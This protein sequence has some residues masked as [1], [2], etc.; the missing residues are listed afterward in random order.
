ML[1]LTSVRFLVAGLL[2][3][4]VS[5]MHCPALRSSG[6]A[7]P[8][9]SAAPSSNV[10]NRKR[11]A[12]PPNGTFKVTRQCVPP[13]SLAISSNGCQD[14]VPTRVSDWSERHPM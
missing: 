1:T 9:P 3:P 2:L 13:D 8:M 14:L 5:A 10:S 7:V 4:A 12:W 6:A 11:G